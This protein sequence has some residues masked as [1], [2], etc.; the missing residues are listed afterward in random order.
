VS[1]DAIGFLPPLQDIAPGSSTAA[2]LD[3]SGNGFA[4]WMGRELAAANA[5]LV[6][7]DQQLQ[8]M[9]AG[10]TTNLHRVMIGLEEA[11]LSFQL[12]VSVRNHLVE[13]YQDILRMQV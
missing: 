8:R 5:Q 3:T 13:G 1:I 7:T 9:A 11:R 6:D 4:A 10:E 2:A 12:L